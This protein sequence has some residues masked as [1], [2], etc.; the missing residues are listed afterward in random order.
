[1]TY[2]DFE[3]LTRKGTDKYCI[4]NHLML[5]KIQIMVDIKRAFLQL[6]I[7]FSIKRLWVVLLKMKSC[8]IKNWLKNYTNRLLENLK[9]KK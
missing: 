6:F 5:L 1:M 3:N 8:K 4:I 7:N 2:E 9:N